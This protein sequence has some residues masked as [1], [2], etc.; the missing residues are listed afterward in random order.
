[1]LSD[2]DRLFGIISSPMAIQYPERAEDEPLH[3]VAAL[4]ASITNFSLLI[5]SAN[6]RMKTL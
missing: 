6:F 2:R 1:M 5:L 4:R 3:C